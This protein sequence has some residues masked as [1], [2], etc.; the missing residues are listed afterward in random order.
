MFFPPHENVIGPIQLVVVK[1]VRVE[2][3]G[4]LVEREE[5]ALKMKIQYINGQFEHKQLLLSF[6]FK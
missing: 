4:V 6:A 2:C 5:L 3:L 1:C